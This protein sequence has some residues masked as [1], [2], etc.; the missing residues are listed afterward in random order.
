ML[1]S[2]AMSAHTNLKRLPDDSP[3]LDRGRWI[4]QNEHAAAIRDIYPVS[5]G[6]TLIVPKRVVFS[7]FELS[8][9]EFLACW[10]L[11]QSERARLVAEFQP[12]GFN[13]GINDGSAAGQTVAHAHMHLI[14]RYTGDHPQPRGGVRAVIPNRA[15]Y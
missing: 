9:A 2:L 10:E 5:D 7:M 4:S 12:D 3:F 8:S 1:D 15:N 11:L 13:V 6:H 14:P